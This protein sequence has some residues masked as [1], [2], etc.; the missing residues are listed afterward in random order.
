[1]DLLTSLEGTMSDKEFNFIKYTLR[2]KAIPTPKMLIKDHK[3][4]KDNGNFPTRLIIPATNFTAGFP[5]LGYTGIRK[6]FDQAKINY[7]K[8]TIVQA[9]DLKG[10]L[11]YLRINRETE[12]VASIDAIDMYPSINFEMVKKSS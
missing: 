8:L 10:D 5:R 9:S 7:K 3:K 4:K 12:T 11:E 6:I 1:M 2:S